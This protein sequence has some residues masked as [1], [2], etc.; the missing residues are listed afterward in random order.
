MPRK[1][2][3]AVTFGLSFLDIMSCGFG[4]VI[5]LF[6][7]IKH[8]VSENIPERVTAPDSASEVMLLEREILEGR[9]GLAELRNTI[10]E[11]DNRI[12]T[13]QGLARK[14]TEELNDTSGQKEAMAA[15]A[16]DS[17]IENLMQDLK[18][19][20]EEKQRQEAETDFTGQDTRSFT[21]E[22][23]RQYLT[24]LRLGGDRILVLL[25]ASASMLD[26]TIINVIR[27]RN[28]SDEIK[29][30]SPKW[31]RALRMVEWLSTRFPVTSKYQVYTFNTSADSVL[32]DTKGQWLEVSDDT[33]LNRVFENLARIIPEGG[34]S[35]EN[36]F[37][38]IS[39]LSP[40]PDN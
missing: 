28:M 34:T 30:N 36:V 37:L 19:M 13:A 32:E 23:N 25:D 4:A 26:D 29:R 24:G 2:T 33:R 15:A 20:E 16:Q 5:L 39:Q 9:E 40:L 31:Q 10:A 6:L 17:E 12:V 21:G 3:S 27:R 14:I 18:R 22:G 38:E 1:R 8:N 35:L 7:I 11:I